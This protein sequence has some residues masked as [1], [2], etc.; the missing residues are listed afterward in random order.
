MKF[1]EGDTLK[2]I[3]RQGCERCER[4][5]TIWRLPVIEILDITSDVKT[6][7]L[8]WKINELYSE[9]LLV[10]LFDKALFYV[11]KWEVDLEEAIRATWID[12]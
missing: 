7:F 9:W 12:N 4:S 6:K 1:E 3:N 8:E 11:K 2:K 10:P 5:W